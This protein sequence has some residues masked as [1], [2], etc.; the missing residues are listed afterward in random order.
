MANAAQWL[1][2]L[3]LFAGLVQLV[4]DSASDTQT[5]DAAKT[6]APVWEPSVHGA[7]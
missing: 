4:L 2:L 6:R 3:V 5:A 1:G 7:R